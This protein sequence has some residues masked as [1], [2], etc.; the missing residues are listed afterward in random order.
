M[1]KDFRGAKKTSVALV[2]LPCNRQR[3]SSDDC[4]EDMF[5]AGLCTILCSVMCTHN[6]AVLTVGVDFGFC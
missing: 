1:S 2:F 4:L 5:C 6:A 3:Q